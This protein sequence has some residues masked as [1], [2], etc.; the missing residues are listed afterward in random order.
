MRTWTRARI[1]TLC[2]NCPTVIQQGQPLLE[3]SAPGWAKVRCDA[4]AGEPAPADLDDQPTATRTLGPRLAERIASI[5]DIG[6]DWKHAQSG[7]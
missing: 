3:I 4:C 5:K 7:E 2:G 6:R 1:N